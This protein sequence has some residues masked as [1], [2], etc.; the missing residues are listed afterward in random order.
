MRRVLLSAGVIVLLSAVPAGATTRLCGT[1]ATP[2][3]S[4]G[5]VVATRVSC[6]TARSVARHFAVYGKVA[7]WH[8][9]AT[10]YEGGAKFLCTQGSGATQRRVRSAIAD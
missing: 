9:N 5:T 4:S 6:A 8:C 1:V 10:A 7:H 3:G 2:T